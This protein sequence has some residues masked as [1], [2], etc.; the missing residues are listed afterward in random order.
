MGRP[1]KSIYVNKEISMREFA[2][3]H[4]T[5]K[6]QILIT[7]EWDPEKEVYD[8]QI[9]FPLN[10]ATVKAN[11]EIEDEDAVN[12]AFENLKSIKNLKT[13]LDQILPFELL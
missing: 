11:I 10:G 3:I 1:I 5:K 12:E 13:T 9:W 4:E 7:K 8:L 2:F 6:G